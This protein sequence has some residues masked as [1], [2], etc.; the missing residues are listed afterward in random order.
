MGLPNHQSD[1]LSS[2]TDDLRMLRVAI[3]GGWNVPAD[4]KAKVKEVI[5][6]ALNSIN[7]KVSTLASKIVVEMESHN[8]SLQKELWRQSRIDGGQSSETIGT[9]EQ[10]QSKV[11]DLLNGLKGKKGI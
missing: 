10:I 7:P 3:R 9:P 8:L 4:M 6:E 11:K 5:E 2:N 1:E